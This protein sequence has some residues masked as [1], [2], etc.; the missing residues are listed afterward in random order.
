MRKMGLASGRWAGIGRGASMKI[1]GWI[2]WAGLVA[3]VAAAAERQQDM[4]LADFEGGSYGDWQT[5]GTA[6]GR[7]PAF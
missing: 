4:V 6:F 7:R 5:T 1:S 2:C 3:S